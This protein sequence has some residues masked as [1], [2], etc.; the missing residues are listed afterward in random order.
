MDRSCSE[1]NRNVQL[2]L[3]D[4][5]QSYYLATHYDPAWYKAWHTWALA[6]FEVVGFLENQHNK[7][8]D[9]PTNELAAHIVSAVTGKESV[10]PTDLSVLIP[11][12]GFFRSIS[13]RNENALQDTL[14]LLTLW[15]KYGAHD[16]VSHAMSNGFTDVEV[17]T[18]LEVIPQI[19][20]RI[21]TPSSNIRR[22]INNLLTEVGKHHPQ[23]LIYPLTVASKSSSA[24]RKK[25]ALN[26]MDRMKEHSPVIV[27][28]ALLVS[29][30]LIRVAILW[31]ELW[32]EGLEE[33]S[34]LYFTDHN[35]M[36][37]IAFLEPL[38]D[39]LEA[40]KIPFAHSTVLLICVCR[41]PKLL[42]KSL[43]PRCL[44]GISTRLVRHAGDTRSM[45]RR[46]I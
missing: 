6:N 9:V 17:D 37:M 32:H 34:R 42:V 21:Q 26:I 15:F 39:M 5:L 33:A 24:V 45:G 7:I 23:A 29:H 19:I 38:H 4:I 11:F 20:A 22:N 2:N 31:H 10:H 16:D 14:R 8:N 12:L 18:W 1:L 41:V 3:K 13:L 30:E 44:E 46:G 28:Q 36:G 35:P 27:E 40:V 25:A 43:S